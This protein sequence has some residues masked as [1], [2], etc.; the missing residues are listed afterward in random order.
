MPPHVT[1]GAYG[2]NINKSWHPVTDCPLSQLNMQPNRIWEA[3]IVAIAQAK[4]QG[5]ASPTTGKGGGV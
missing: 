5:R 4:Q 2:L 3:V 1:H